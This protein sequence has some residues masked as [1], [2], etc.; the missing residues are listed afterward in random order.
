MASDHR[1]ARLETK[2]E[3]LWQEQEDGPP[4]NDGPC[5]R[6]IDLTAPVVS[7]IAALSFQLVFAL[8]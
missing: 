5:V 6:Y 1:S 4:R 7:Q 2:E 8:A 3:I